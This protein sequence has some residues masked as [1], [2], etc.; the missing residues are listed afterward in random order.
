MA[1]NQVV[2]KKIFTRT[3][4]FHSKGKVDFVAKLTQALGNHYLAVKTGYTTQ[5]CLVN[6]PPPKS[7]III[8]ERPGSYK[9]VDRDEAAYFIIAENSIE[10]KTSKWSRLAF[11]TIEVK[12]S[13]AHV[14]MGSGKADGEFKIGIG[15]GTVA[16]YVEDEIDPNAIEDI[17]LPGLTFYKAEGFST[18]RERLKESRE[19]TLDLVAK[20]LADSGASR[21]QGRLH[22]LPFDKLTL[23]KTD[24]DRKIGLL[25]SSTDGL[26]NEREK[27]GFRPVNSVIMS[28]PS[29]SPSSSFSPSSTIMNQRPIFRP[30]AP[31]PQKTESSATNDLFKFDTSKISWSAQMEEEDAIPPTDPRFKLIEEDK[32]KEPVV[33][34]NTPQREII[35]RIDQN[36]EALVE[37]ALSNKEVMD[38]TSGLSFSDPAESGTFD[39]VI[40]AYSFQATTLPIFEVNVTSGKYRSV[41]TGASCRAYI[42]I[43]GRSVLVLPEASLQ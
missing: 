11:E 30:A 32:P 27:G 12:T 3:Y 5:T 18:E 20:S 21:A 22:G 4:L 23:L 9:I 43:G 15:R 33:V 34:R 17:T 16:P 26:L 28:L 7:I 19:Q 37:S 31:I 6:H 14:D 41:G 38:H 10:F 13:F 1:S 42:V 25:S 8:I 35:D 29:N 24:S 36:Y 40:T 39:Q 2:E